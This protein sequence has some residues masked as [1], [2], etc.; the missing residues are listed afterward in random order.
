[1]KTLRPVLL[2]GQ[3]SV[4]RYSFRTLK[5]SPTEAGAKPTVKE[6]CCNH[7]QRVDG[8][9][10][11]PAH[12]LS[13]TGTRN[14]L[15]AASGQPS[16]YAMFCA[17]CCGAYREETLPI[18]INKSERS[19]FAGIQRVLRSITVCSSGYIWLAASVLE[20]PGLLPLLP[21]ACRLQR[22]ARLLR[23]SCR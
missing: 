15:S 3:S 4:H 1:M 13:C 14:R 19:L 7:L 2:L 16:D 12:A 17:G 20:R 21:R 11:K 22:P 18:A 9:G 5:K 6:I 10:A 23:C 8:S